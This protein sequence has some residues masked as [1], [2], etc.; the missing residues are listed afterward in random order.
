MGL[1]PKPA[2]PV[3]ET[4]LGVFGALRQPD[5]R[6]LFGTEAEIVNRNAEGY[7]TKPEEAAPSFVQIRPGPTS[8][9][10]NTPSPESKQG[11]SKFGKPRRYI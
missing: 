6:Y 5:A 3:K 9:D 10:L 1:E 11:N 7:N 8:K 2:R 4:P